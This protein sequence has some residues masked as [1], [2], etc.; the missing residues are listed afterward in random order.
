MSPAAIWM[1]RGAR[2]LV[3]TWL[4][5]LGAGL[6]VPAAAVASD[7]SPV[8]PAEHRTTVILV[9]GA[10][11]E[12]E[13]GEPFGL[14][15][16]NWQNACLRADAI[17]H[18]I[19]LTPTNSQ[20]DKDLLQALLSREANTDASEL[21]LVLIGHGTFD[22]KEA[23][24]NLRGPDLSAADLAGWLK[25][26]HRPLAIIDAASSSG[27]FISQ[28][29]APGRVIITATRSGFEQ[30][31]ARFGQYLS[32]AV[33]DPE[34]DLD[35]DGQISLLEAFLTAANRVAEFY[36]VEGR[37]AT[38]HALLDD[39]GDSR[40]TPAE[41]FRGLRAVKKPGDNAALDGLR[42]HQLH[43]VRSAADRER[44]PEQRARRD[45]LERAVIAHRDKKG[46]MAE[47]DYYRE[48]EKLLL[49]LAP[50][51]P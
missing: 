7:N 34:A 9:V 47:D 50:F 38:E 14:W 18:M 21:W 10:A 1:K 41:W 6:I 30:N 40:G 33:T 45:E 22:G 25:P 51:Y 8:P 23:K 36:K 15:A 42:A 2:W 39:N 13:F 27:P 46:Q 12:A 48:L 29:S 44:S 32:V 43:L 17:C 37:L 19:G 31:Y 49:Q 4:A 5:L 16:T 28:L 26:F 24:F 20:T 35:K 3:M 11:G